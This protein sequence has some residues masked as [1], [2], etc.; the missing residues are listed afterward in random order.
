MFSQ[1]V[2]LKN[3]VWIACILLVSC[4]DLINV[5]TG[6]SDPILNIDAWVNDKEETQVI[7][8]TMTQDYFDNDDLPPAASGATV[9]ITDSEDNVYEFEEDLEAADGSYNWT[10]SADTTSMVTSGLSYTLTVVYEGETY[11]ATSKA[12][13]VPPVDSITLEYEEGEGFASDTY[14][15]QFWATDPEGT[16]DT[17]WIKTYK[18]GTLLNKTSEINIAYDAGT[19]SSS[20]YDGVTFISSV[21]EGINAMEVDDDD[22]PESPFWL[23]DSVYVEIH[24]LTEASFNYM[25]EVVIQTDRAGG[26]SE[27]F[28]ST[29][30][31][32]V[33]TNIV[34]LDGNGSSVVGFFNVAVTSGY[35]KELEKSDILD[36]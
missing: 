33:S 11:Q 24:S 8:L 22:M 13:R 21:R 23:G 1:Y 7:Y 28:T 16:G 5:S 17:Y 18:D 19:S 27:I 32:N 3:L 20:G 26:I 9:T 14:R 29:P 2:Q 34:N 4:D 36:D 30:L 12:G 15:A 10:P 31:A 35:G 6:S 25:S